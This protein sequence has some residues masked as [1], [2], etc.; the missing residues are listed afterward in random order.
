MTVYKIYSDPPVQKT[1]FLNSETFKAK[2]TRTHITY[3]LIRVPN[4]FIHDV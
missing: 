2:Y 3:C 1:P 4:N